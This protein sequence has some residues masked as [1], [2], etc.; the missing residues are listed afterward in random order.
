M[1]IEFCKGKFEEK[2]N[3]LSFRSIV[4]GSVVWLE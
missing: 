2:F 4:D 1:C 3:C